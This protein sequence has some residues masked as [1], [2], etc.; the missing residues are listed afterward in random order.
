MAA[1]RSSFAMDSSCRELTWQ[2]AVVCQSPVGILGC[3]I[4]GCER[5]ACA[6]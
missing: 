1:F 5:L 4:L 6:L 2:C 3:M